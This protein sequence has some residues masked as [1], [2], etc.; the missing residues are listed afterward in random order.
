MIIIV[1]GDVTLTKRI[2]CRVIDSAPLSCDSAGL[3][4]GWSLDTGIYDN[5]DY[6][7]TYNKTS[8]TNKTKLYSEPV[9]NTLNCFA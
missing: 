8:A 9:E 2:T 7:I 6:L 5:D 4:F 3:H 1:G